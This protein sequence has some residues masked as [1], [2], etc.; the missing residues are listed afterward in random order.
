MILATAG[1]HLADGS[2]QVCM[3]PL[4]EH[5]A[6]RTESECLFHVERVPLRGHDDNLMLGMRAP[7]MLGG[8]TREGSSVR[9]GC[10]QPFHHRH[11]NIHENDIRLA[12]SYRVEQC[13]AP[14]AIPTTSYRRAERGE[15]R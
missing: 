1:K 13:A 3:H 6:V 15:N 8:N 11:R 14:P 9:K 5:T 7:E 10:N 12:P 2:D 4:L